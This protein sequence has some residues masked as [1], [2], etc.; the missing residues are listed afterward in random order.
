MSAA[1]LKKL[2]APFRRAFGE[3]ADA[4]HGCKAGE[5]SQPSEPIEIDIA[6]VSSDAGDAA[7]DKG[8]AAV[9]KSAAA[10]HKAAPAVD[11]G[12]AAKADAA[13]DAPAEAGEAAAAV[14]KA[15]AAVVKAAV[16]GASVARA[17]ADAA[18]V[19]GV[20]A[21]AK[22]REFRETSD[23]KKLVEATSPRPRV[24]HIEDAFLKLKE[25]E[26]LVLALRYYEKL[27]ESDVASILHMTISEVQRIQQ[28]A[29]SGVIRYLA[30]ASKG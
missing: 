12:D 24:G 4:V 14:A 29:L 8:D 25:K 5:T 1:A 3:A 27:T 18:P 13:A 19:D 6:S 17:A 9:E 15:V 11:K 30:C 26:R 7:A 2:L 20:D 21:S 28:E 10:V 23:T 16:P 22:S